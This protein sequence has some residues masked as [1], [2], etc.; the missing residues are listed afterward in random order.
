M[1]R[2][3]ACV[4][5]VVEPELKELMKRV[6]AK[7]GIQVSDFIRICIIERLTAMGYEIK[8]DP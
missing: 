2:K 4:T 3:T 8:S 1:G 6:S 5:F 7:Q